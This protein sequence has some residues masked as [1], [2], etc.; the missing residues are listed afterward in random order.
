MALWLCACAG[1][2]VGP[3][4]APPALLT[5]F[6]FL[7]ER[8][9]ESDNTPL[10]PV[11]WMERRGEARVPVFDTGK[12]IELVI[13][14]LQ[15]WGLEPVIG[16]T[17]L[18]VREGPSRHNLSVGEPR[19]I[20]Y[21]HQKGLLNVG[22]LTE[23]E[24]VGVFIQGRLHRLDYELLLSLDEV[25]PLT[26][27]SLNRMAWEL[28]TYHDESR[29]APIVA[30]ELAARANERSNWSNVDHLDTLAAAYAATGDFKHAAIH[31]QWAILAAA[32]SGPGMRE[33]LKLYLRDE[34]YV[35]AG[36]SAA[37]LN[38]Q[39]QALYE[40]ATQGDAAA[41][42]EFALHCYWEELDE[43]DGISDPGKHFLILAAEQGEVGAIEEIGYSLLRGES[44][45]EANPEEARRWLE[46]AVEEGGSLAAYNLAMM[47][48]DGIGVER[49]AALATHWLKVAADRGLHEAAVEVAYRYLEGIGTEPLP[50]IADKYFERAAAA[51]VGP[52]LTMYGEEIYPCE[53][54]VNEMAE[55]ALPVLAISPRDFP[56]HLVA[57]ADSMSRE[58]EV[59]RQIITARFPNSYVGWERQDA[60]TAIYLLTHAAAIFGSR[61]A[62]ERVAVLYEN[63]TGVTASDD[64]A[65]YWRNRAANNRSDF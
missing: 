49:D 38:P 30:L 21:G 59:G 60:P 41:Q 50:A 7:P 3:A 26:G 43:V 37:T 25:E 57:T 14:T 58:L 53:E 4:E 40:K 28:A 19:L 33:R 6:A 36:D 54:L 62:Q 12:P 5:R 55:E 32:E 22:P 42:F 23:D 56:R 52:M 10:G 13:M 2:A 39:M 34:A 1:Q 45:W 20:I 11:H 51:G 29:R 64:L 15:Q 63:G 46:R 61:E 24:M 27:R 44:G 35:Q 16:R 31:Q 18:I 47:Y 9:D 48:R 65:R 17:S 8:L